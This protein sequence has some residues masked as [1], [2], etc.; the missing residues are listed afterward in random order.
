[1]K[2][3]ADLTKQALKIHLSIQGIKQVDIAKSIGIAPGDVNKVIHGTSKSPAH[4]KKVYTFLGL[5]P[6]RKC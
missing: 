4:V 3:A 6:P 5:E 1:L 2:T